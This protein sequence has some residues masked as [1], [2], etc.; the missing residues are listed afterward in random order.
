MGPRQGSLLQDSLGKKKSRGLARKDRNRPPAGF[1]TAIAPI[2]G[3][4][5]AQA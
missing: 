1:P 2:S 5:Q 4:A 3:E